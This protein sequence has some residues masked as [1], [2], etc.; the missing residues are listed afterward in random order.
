MG[1]MAVVFLKGGLWGACHAAPVQAVFACMRQCPGLAA[2]W[3]SPGGLEVPGQS[4]VQPVPFA[5]LADFYYYYF[6]VSM[7]L[8]PC[9]TPA[10][11]GA[12]AGCQ[13]EHALPL[14]TCLPGIP[15]AC[16][17]GAPSP[18][19]GDQRDPGIPQLLWSP[20]GS[21][22]PPA[23]DASLC[24]LW[25]PSCCRFPGRDLHRVSEQG[26][27]L[28]SLGRCGTLATG[29]VEGGIGGMRCPIAKNLGSWNHPPLPP[30]CG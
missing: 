6:Y 20:P 30:H 25:L 18:G 19:H 16:S 23:R 27:A 4:P 8:R 2:V 15:H 29:R 3:A 9:S 24:S 5:E 13:R 28:G 11:A 14:L 26:W 21:S 12:L 10:P 17:V 22:H 7:R 1:G